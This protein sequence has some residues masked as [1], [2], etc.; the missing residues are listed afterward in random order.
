MECEI[1]TSAIHA[2]LLECIVIRCSALRLLRTLRALI[3]TLRAL[4]MR[5]VMSIH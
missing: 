1:T 2:T 5:Y 4:K 3:R